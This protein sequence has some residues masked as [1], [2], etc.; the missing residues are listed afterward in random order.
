MSVCQRQVNRARNS[1][2]VS[3]FGVVRKCPACKRQTK[4]RRFLLPMLRKRVDG[5]AA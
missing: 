4:Q 3:S 1:R 5:M 2:S